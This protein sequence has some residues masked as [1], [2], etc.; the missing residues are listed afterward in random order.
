ML[1]V[2]NVTVSYDTAM[3]LDEA[4]L[5]DWIIAQKD[6]NPKGLG[7]EDLTEDM[8]NKILQR[9]V[10]MDTDRQKETANA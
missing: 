6:I 2:K 5:K 4:S 8:M 3:V 10:K 7:M 1:E 9:I